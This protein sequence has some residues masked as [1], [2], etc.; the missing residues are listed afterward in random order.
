MPAG[1]E[2]TA[3]QVVAERLATDLLD[4]GGQH[5]VP[6][7][8][9]RQRVP[10]SNRSGAWATALATASSPVSQGTGCFGVL[11]RS[12]VPAVCSSSWRIEMRRARPL[13]G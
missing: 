6:L 5:H 4:D 12:P 10:G 9:V 13:S 1:R 2:D 8:A 11:H 3:L 7:V